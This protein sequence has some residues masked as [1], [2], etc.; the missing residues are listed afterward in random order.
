MS[1]GDDEWRI[2]KPTEKKTIIIVK[3]EIE[4][5]AY[6]KWECDKK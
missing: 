5:I 4:W 3:K 6:L 1:L 2:E